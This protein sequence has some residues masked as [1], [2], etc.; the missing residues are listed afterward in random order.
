MLTMLIFIG[1]AYPHSGQYV[2]ISR[3]VVN[4]VQKSL[5]SLL[6]IGKNPSAL[7]EEVVKQFRRHHRVVGGEVTATGFHDIGQNGLDKIPV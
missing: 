4:V 2:L 1:L 6:Q 5:L 3:K 7:I